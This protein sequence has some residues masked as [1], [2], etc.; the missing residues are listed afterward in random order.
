MDVASL[1]ST[2]RR[3]HREN[4]LRP[5]LTRNSRNKVDINR[6]KRFDEQQQKE[7]QNGYSEQL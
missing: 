1:L 2:I 5:P 7:F 6:Q 3:I 4:L